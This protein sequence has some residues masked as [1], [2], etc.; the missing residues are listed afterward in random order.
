M[1]FQNRPVKAVR[2]HIGVQI[3]HTVTTSLVADTHKVEMELW[4]MGVAYTGKNNKGEAVAGLIPY[5]NIQ[6][7]EMFPEEAAKPAAKGSKAG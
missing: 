5:S 7:L 1:S 6:S 2:I 3:N 4:P